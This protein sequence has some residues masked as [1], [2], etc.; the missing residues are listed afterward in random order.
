MIRA[1]GLEID[2]QDLNPEMEWLD[3]QHE[4]H[5]GPVMVVRATSEN[6]WAT[7]DVKSD[8]STW[9]TTVNMAVCKPEKSALLLLQT[10]TDLYQKSPEFDGKLYHPIGYAYL[11]AAGRLRRKRI[12]AGHISYSPDIQALLREFS[13]LGIEVVEYERATGSRPRS[14]VGK[15]CT[16]V[17]YEGWESMVAAYLGEKVLPLLSY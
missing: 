11:D 9:L 4:L 16:L 17:D 14:Y 10:K 7:F 8:S 12:S 6:L 3:V 15:L 2:I 5:R 13:N 1:F